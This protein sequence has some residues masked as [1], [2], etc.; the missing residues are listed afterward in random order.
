VIVIPMGT[1]APIYHWPYATVGLIVLNVA[2]LFAVPPVSSAP[3]LDDD[4]EIVEDVESVSNFD[5]YALAIGD[6]RLHPVQ[7]VTHNFLHNGLVHLAGNMLFLW[8]FGIVVEGK[9]GP[10]KY[11]LTYLAIGALHGALVQTSL[12]K[13]GLDGHAAGASAVVY[14]LLAVCMVWAPRNELNCLAILLVGFRTFV[15]HWDLYYTTVALIYFGEQV[16][17]LVVW[18]ALGGRVMI[19]EMGHLSGAFWGMVVAFALLKGG[20]VDCEGWDLFSLWTKRRK[21]AGDWKKRGEQLDRHK[22]NIRASVKANARAKFSNRDGMGNTDGPSREQRSAAAVR[23]I[24]SLIDAGD[25][26]GALTSYDKSARTLF[27][28]PSQP[29]LYEMIKAMHARGAEPDSIR[30]MR[31][32]C[33]YYPGDSSKVRLKLAQVLIR[34]CQRPTA[35][36]RVLEEIPP[37]S[38]HPD[39]E[40]ARQKLARQADRMREEGVLELE[41]D[42]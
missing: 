11:L 3:A 35:A 31:D 4:G 26:P 17:G 24:R 21:L 10:V 29:D 1:D 16:V 23:R 14:G 5:R 28:W 12:M 18:G 41:G 32:H 15:F 8:A 2:L 42:D 13:S 34:N 25:I 40:T 33:R 19:T 39:L 9:L 27:D 20:L 6:G 22:E 38:L 30:L 36:L 37:G 7:W